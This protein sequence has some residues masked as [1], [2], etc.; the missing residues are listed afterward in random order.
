M[1]F[2]NEFST[3][4]LPEYAKD[5]GFSLVK[6]NWLIKNW[7]DLHDKLD[8]ITTPEEA[9]A[10]LM[11]AATDD[12]SPVIIGYMQS[13]TKLGTLTSLFQNKNDLA[14]KGLEIAL[15]KHLNVFHSKDT[16]AVL[17]GGANIATANSKTVPFS[18][19]TAEKILGCV[20]YVVSKDLLNNISYQ[21]SPTE[22]NASDVILSDALIY[23]DDYL[24]SMYIYV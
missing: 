13:S 22:K 9:A 7:S 24:T 8:F 6:Y 18:S 20:N 19:E 5:A 1:V 12:T 21:N 14:M 23:I 3:I 4:E 2:M 16:L 11:I 17:L 15:T 10:L